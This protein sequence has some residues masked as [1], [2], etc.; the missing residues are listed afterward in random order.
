MQ[1]ASS[2]FDIQ[3][4]EFSVTG[5]PPTDDG[6][7]RDSFLKL[8][9]DSY[10][11]LMT[12]VE[13][14]TLNPKWSFSKRFFYKTRFLDNSAASF[15]PSNVVPEEHRLLLEKPRWISILYRPVLILTNLHFTKET[16]P[17]EC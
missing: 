2:Q 12:D 14:K 11:H 17:R 7:P 15:S 13:E 8:D 10:K 9:F 6:G 1:S 16:N 5:L 4:F 3:L